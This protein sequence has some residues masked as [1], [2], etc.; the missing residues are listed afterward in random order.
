MTFLLPESDPNPKTYMYPNRNPIFTC[1][2]IIQGLVWQHPWSGQKASNKFRLKWQSWTYKMTD[3][4]KA[5]LEHKFGCRHFHHH[6]SFLLKFSFH[7]FFSCFFSFFF[8]KDECSSTP[9]KRQTIVLINRAWKCQ[10]MSTSTFEN[11]TWKKSKWT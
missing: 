3:K 4:W 11:L 10:N 1:N 9:V 8:F 6:H 2:W 5:Q 7:I